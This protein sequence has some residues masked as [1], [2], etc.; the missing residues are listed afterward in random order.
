MQREQ[1]KR[2]SRQGKAGV[3]AEHRKGVD[4][5]LMRQEVMEDSGLPWTVDFMGTEAEGPVQRLL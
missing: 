4:L 5:Y 2:S 1:R 3:G